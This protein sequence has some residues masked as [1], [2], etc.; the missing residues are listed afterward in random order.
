MNN[1]GSLAPC[2]LPIC[3]LPLIMGRWGRQGR[4]GMKGRQGRFVGQAV[5]GRA[6]AWQEASLFADM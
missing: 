1:T 4:H 5:W 2:P 3:P 6:G